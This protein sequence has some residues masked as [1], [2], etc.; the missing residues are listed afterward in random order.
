M[1]NGKCTDWK[2]GGK[3]ADKENDGKCKCTD[4]KSAYQVKA[5]VLQ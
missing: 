4:R 2:N 3:C 5:V 1:V